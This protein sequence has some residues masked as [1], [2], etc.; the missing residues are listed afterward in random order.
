MKTRDDDDLT[1]IISVVYDE[2]N[3]EL[4]WSIGS[5]VEFDQN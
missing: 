2:N 4:L 3:T 5:G 1:V